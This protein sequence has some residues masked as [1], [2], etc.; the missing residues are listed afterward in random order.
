[1]AY[2]ARKLP[3]QAW[4]VSQERPS[5]DGTPFVQTLCVCDRQADAERIAYCLRI[6]AESEETEAQDMRDVAL[7]LVPPGGSA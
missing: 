3:G 1:M 2:F 7:F 5:D 6:V 4:A